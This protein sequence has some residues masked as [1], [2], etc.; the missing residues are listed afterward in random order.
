MV[1]WYGGW[2][3][4]MPLTSD[5]QFDINPIPVN[6]TLTKAMRPTDVS[7][8]VVR[9]RTQAMLLPSSGAG[10]GQIGGTE[11]K[12]RQVWYNPEG[13]HSLPAFLNSL[14]NFILRA[15][16]PKEKSSNYGIAVVAHPYP[17]GESQEQAML[18]SLLDIIV[19]MSVLIGYSI[20]T[21]SFVLYV[22]KEHQNKAKQLQHISGLGV[23][24]YWVTNFIYDLVYFMV[25]V[26][27]SIGVISAFQIPAFFNDN[28]LLAVFLLLFLF[29]YA[30]FSWMYLLAGIFKET[31]MAFI[32]YVC[33]NLF[34]GINTIITHSVVFL[35]SQEKA[36]DQGLN[37]LAETLRHV[38]LMFPQF[39]FGSGLIELSQHQALMGFLKAYGVVY[40]DTTFELDRISSKLLGLFL[41]GTLF[42]SVRLLVDDGTIQKVWY[43]ILE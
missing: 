3:F 5:L 6:R 38:F 26:A 28:N 33:I 11:R 27:L 19:S 37:D 18:S 32:V 17:G 2:S 4:G 22:V 24:S 35:L 15:N 9:H 40:P 1:C 7:G 14:N 25:P 43:K 13:Y 39:C 16:V 34:F 20:T 29:G 31:G 10:E 30:T 12:I 42:F 41:Q 8:V 36:T 23:T 21:A